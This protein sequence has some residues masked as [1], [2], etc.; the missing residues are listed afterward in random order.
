MDRPAPGALWAPLA[1]PDTW[2]SLRAAGDLGPSG[3]D[4][5]ALARRCAALAS[6]PAPQPRDARTLLVARQTH[7]LKVVVICQGGAWQ[8]REG[9]WRTGGDGRESLLAF[10]DGESGQVDARDPGALAAFAASREADG[11]L[12]DDAFLHLG[13]TVADCG[14]LFVGA[15]NWRGLLHSGW[16]GTGILAVCL[17]ALAGIDPGAVLDARLYQGPC[18]AAADYPV[19]PDRAALFASRFGPEAVVTCPDGQPGLDL[20]A[21]NRALLDRRAPCLAAQSPGTPRPGPAASGTPGAAPQ[22]G[23]SGLS[24]P[25]EPWLHSFR[26]DTA[27]SCGRMLALWAGKA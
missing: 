5:A 19:P 13:V 1:W 3:M 20:L 12:T 8:E 27:A 15:G 11:W 25:R 17:D 26:R 9:F 22:G 6:L 2:L 21:A 18:I 24:T 14:N 10:R 16:G 7:S 4:E 23:A